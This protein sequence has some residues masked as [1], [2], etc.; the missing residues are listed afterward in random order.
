MAL[1]GDRQYAL[2]LRGT[3]WFFVSSVAEEGSD[4]RQPEISTSGRDTAILFQA[5]QK[6]GDQWCIDLFEC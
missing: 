5:F 4:R 1:T 6:R 2:D 3:R